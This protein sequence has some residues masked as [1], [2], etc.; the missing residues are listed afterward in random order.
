M[1]LV[2]IGGKRASSTEP[3]LKYSRFE[4]TLAAGTRL[5]VS[6]AAWVDAVAAVLLLFWW[7]I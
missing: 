6:H 4:N 3:E 1:A 5:T 7:K 2:F